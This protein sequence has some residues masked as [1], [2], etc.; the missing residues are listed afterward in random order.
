M[1]KQLPLW[2]FERSYKAGRRKKQLFVKIISTF[3]FLPH[4]YKNHNGL[5]LRVKFDIIF[6][7][8]PECQFFLTIAKIR[9]FYILPFLIPACPA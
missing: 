5:R 4:R 2:D 6:I 7:I 3:Y 8:L 1:E 9:L